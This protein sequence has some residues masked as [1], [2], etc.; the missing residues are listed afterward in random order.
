MSTASPATPAR[1]RPRP[2]AAAA[3]PVPA[4]PVP[5]PGETACAGFGN[6]DTYLMLDELI[7]RRGIR[8]RYNEGIIEIMSI[9][10]LHEKLK[11]RLGRFLEAYC[12]HKGVVY[13]MLGST[14][15]LQQGKRA[16]EPDESYTFGPD[17]KATPD[18]V[19]EV[20][21]TSGGMDKLALWAGLG[22]PELWLWQ[23]DSLHF[24]HLT[25]DRYAPANDSQFLPGFPV[26]LVT[27]AM[28]VA[29]GS[30]A[31]EE[32][33]RGLVGNGRRGAGAPGVS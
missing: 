12:R 25:G 3:P 6:W 29:K 14:T 24:F 18:L 30:E 20:A 4:F 2:R 19:I 21:L 28:A 8:V 31:V 32:F 23:N 17:Q 33:T 11:S 26:P 27:A 10:P 9:S 7:G 5:A 22:V 16:A 15:Q 1:K 13:E